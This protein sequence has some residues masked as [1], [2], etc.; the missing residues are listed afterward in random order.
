MFNLHKEVEEVKLEY[1]IIKELRDGVIELSLSDISK[2]LD[3]SRSKAQRLIDKFI[4]LDILVVEKKSTSK[5]KKTIY[6]YIKNIN[7]NTNINTNIS[8]I[9]N[10]YIY[11]S[12]T[13]ND[14]KSNMMFEIYKKRYKLNSFIEEKLSLYENEVTL[15]L[16]E[17][18]LDHIST[19]QNIIYKDKY[20]IS[21]LDDLKQNNVKT[22]EEFMNHT[23]NH[24]EVI[25][26]KKL[27]EKF[28][29]MVGNDLDEDFEELAKLSRLR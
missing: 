4:K 10:E 12:D 6:R 24:K 13:E 28:G 18:I 22:L 25:R 3:V 16:F 2:L 11:N 19:R 26:K 5:N 1:Y 14:I 21:L 7:I 27:A 9:N 20:L 17:Y 29:Y 23:T 8:V 15:E